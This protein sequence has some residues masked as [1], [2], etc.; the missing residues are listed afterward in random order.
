VFRGAKP[1]LPLADQLPAYHFFM[2]MNTFFS[3]AKRMSCVGQLRNLL[4]LQHFPKAQD[5]C[6]FADERVAEPLAFLSVDLFPLTRTTFFV[7]MNS[8]QREVRACDI[9][10]ARA[11]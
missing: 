10:T 7:S 5:R 4:C 8:G 6:A 9:N 3:T 2:Q 11:T 1:C